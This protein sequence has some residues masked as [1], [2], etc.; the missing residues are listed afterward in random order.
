MVF[1]RGKIIIKKSWEWEEGDEIFAPGL[2]QSWKA[3]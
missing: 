1:T 3:G 2:V